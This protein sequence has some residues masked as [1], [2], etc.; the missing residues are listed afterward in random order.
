[1]TDKRKEVFFVAKRYVY[2]LLVF[3]LILISGC[4]GGSDPGLPPEE[5]V[6]ENE[7]DR[8]EKAISEMS[9]RQ[10]IAGLIIVGIEG[11]SVNDWIKEMW[12]EYPFGGVIIYERNFIREDWLKEFI[13]ELSDLSN[14]EYPLL[15][16]TDE[17]G[18][19][20]TRLPGE[21]FPNAAELAQMNEEEVYQTGQAMAEKLNDYGIKVNFAPVLDINID[22]RNTVIGSR[23]FGSDPELVSTFGIALYRGMESNGVIS[24]GKHYPG[25]GST[26]ADS[27]IELPV[28]DK[29]REELY[30]F[31]LIPFHRA[32]EAGIPMIMTAHLI[33][34]GIDDKPATMSKALIGILRDE[35]QFDGVIVSDDLEMG[36]LTENFS[37][38]D[39]IVETFLAGV[40]LL[41]I[42]HSYD[43]QVDAVRILEEAYDAGIISDERLNSSLRRVMEIRISDN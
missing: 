28:L 37:W 40:D 30:A 4:S 24:V 18:G 1:L 10:K 19:S 29:N 22:P 2:L 31:E 14:P 35:L 27:H 15:V 8:I 36:A 17:E 43:A 6:V 32:V 23:S 39:I 33:V 16:C 21:T 26:L 5:E 25:H 7:P 9:L 11:T 3:V 41:L 38:D 34:S 13:S 12:A 42:G 20:I